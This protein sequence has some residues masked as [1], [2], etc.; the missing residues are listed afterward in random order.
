MPVS[1]PDSV[2]RKPSSIE[3][4]DVIAPVFVS[5]RV[6]ELAVEKLNSAVPD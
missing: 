3:A 5:V 1:V 6:N 2:K 4:M